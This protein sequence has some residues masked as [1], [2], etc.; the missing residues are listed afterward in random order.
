MYVCM[1]VCVCV[2]V[3]GSNSDFS[4]LDFH[5]FFSV[6]FLQGKQIVLASI[7]SSQ[8]FL[9][10]QQISLIFLRCLLLSSP[11]LGPYSESEIYLEVLNLLHRPFR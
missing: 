8:S 9:F 5:D 1:C 7:V 10:V 11:R 4:L 2:C 6:L 3:S